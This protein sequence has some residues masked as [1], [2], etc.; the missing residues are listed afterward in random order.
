MSRHSYSAIWSAPDL[1]RGFCAYSAQ[2]TWLSG[3]CM[4]RGYVAPGAW[5]GLVGR[6]GGAA[7]RRCR[8]TS[9]PRWRPGGQTGPTHPSPALRPLAPTPSCASTRPRRPR[10]RR[11]RTG[12]VR[13]RACAWRP[14]R[15]RLAAR[16]AH[17]GA[18]ARAGSSAPTRRCVDSRARRTQRLR[19]NCPRKAPAGPRAPHPPVQPRHLQCRTPAAGQELT[20]RQAS[21]LPGHRVP[22]APGPRLRLATP[23]APNWCAAP[24]ATAVAVLC[25]CTRGSGFRFIPLTCGAK[26]TRTP[27]LL[28]AISRQHVHPCLSPQVTVPE[29]TSGSASVRGGCCTFLL[30]STSDYWRIWYYLAEAAGLEVWL[31]NAREVKHLPGRGKSTGKTACGCAS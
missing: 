27:G 12:A 11:G 3:R 23:Q 20:D 4:R 8:A 19:A 6:T 25:C 5:P 29:R 21:I 31:V 13:P 22:S 17:L 26:G 18:A 9:A 7:S 28:H 16:E 15:S 14:F 2:A 30:E 10:T 1:A 24:H